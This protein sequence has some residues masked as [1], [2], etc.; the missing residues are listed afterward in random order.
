[1]DTKKQ[2][3]LI[4]GLSD[5]NM[6]GTCIQLKASFLTFCAQVVYK[7]QRLKHLNMLSLMPGKYLHLLMEI[8]NCPTQIEMNPIDRS[9]PAHH[10]PVWS[11]IIHMI[12]YLKT[13][14][15]KHGPWAV[16]LTQLC[17]GNIIQKDILKSIIQHNIMH[18]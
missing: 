4:L 15:V 13:T 11:I 7:C 12:K 16:Y 6:W 8:E 14:I 2:S 10:G 1:M 17:K 9:C 5:N 3:V 18:I